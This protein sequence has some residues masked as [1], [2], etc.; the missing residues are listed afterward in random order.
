MSDDVWRRVFG[1]GF[2]FTGQLYP[3]LAVPNVVEEDT[4]PFVGC[5]TRHCRSCRGS[6][7][8][9]VSM[10]YVPLVTWSSIRNLSASLKRGVNDRFEVNEWLLDLA[11][12]VVCIR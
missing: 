1:D 5:S 4:Y 9:V 11:D 7:L 6:N 10:K 3:S 8:D 12:V 2:V